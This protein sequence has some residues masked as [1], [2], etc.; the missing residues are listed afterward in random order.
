MGFEQDGKKLNQQGVIIYD[1]D[2]RRHATST[3]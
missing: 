2:S 1:Q 3:V